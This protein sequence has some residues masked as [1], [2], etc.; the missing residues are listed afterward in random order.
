RGLF[1]IF[2]D[3]SEED[4]KVLVRRAIKNI[5]NKLQIPHLDQV[6]YIYGVNMT[7][8]GQAVHNTDDLLLQFNDV[9]DNLERTQFYR[10]SG[11]QSLMKELTAKN[12]ELIKERLYPNIDPNS[13]RS[14]FIEMS[15]GGVRL[16]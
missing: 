2:S 7:L 14:I 8:E 16:P 9:F 12:G 6:I 1:E 15:G 4:S 13:R 3:F 11:E 10:M 5:E